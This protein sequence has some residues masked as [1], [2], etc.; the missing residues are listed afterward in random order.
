MND[1]VNDVKPPPPTRTSV[2]RLKD[3]KSLAEAFQTEELKSLIAA[4]APKF[5]DPAAMLRT[6][7]QAAARQPLIYK[8]DFR[9]ALGAF[10]SLAFLGLQP[11]THLN[12]AHIIPFKKKSWN[13]LTR[14]RDKESVEIQVII[15]YPGYIELAHRSGVVKAL[16]ADVV[17]DA[18]AEEFDYEY[19]T[20]QHLRHRGKPPGFKPEHDPLYAYAWFKLEHADQFEVM[21]WNEVLTIRSRSQ[22]YRT[23]ML[24]HDEAK[25]ENKRIPSTYTDA[26]WIRDFEEMGKKSALRRGMKWLPKCPELRAA[27]ALED[28]QDSGAL[29]W[30]PVIDGSA[31]PLDG[32]IPEG[33]PDREDA[34][35]P[36]VAGSLQTQRPSQRERQPREPRQPPPKVQDVEVL[37]FEAGIVDEFGEIA[38]DVITDPEQF[39]RAL[40]AHWRRMPD[41]SR[42]EALLDFNADA[43]DALDKMFPRTRPIIAE[44]RPDD[45]QDEPQGAAGEPVGSGQ[46][47]ERY[48]PAAVPAG[49][50]SGRSWASYVADVKAALATIPPGIE[51]A[52]RW[53]EA[54]QATLVSAPPAQRLLAINAISQHLAKAGLSAVPAWMSDLVKPKAK[55][56]PPSD[57]QGND[58]PPISADEKQ[59]EGFEKNVQA[60]LNM[61]PG[62]APLVEFESYAKSGAVQA[63]MKRLRE[64]N[65][66]LYDRAYR[67]FD[68]GQAELRKRAAKSPPASGDVE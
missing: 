4:A 59:V 20:N 51:A 47:D 68:A 19:G 25:A 2:A 15:G 58:A 5:I 56:A 9:Q 30:G 13:P 64:T 3:C 27:A 11:N 34:G 18:R 17:Y 8:A 60:Y 1:T 63:A 66:P 22:S 50:S 40:L 36:T 29:D 28:A 23:A 26:P 33:E 48:A 49:G 44:I 46:P 39:A 31:S 24:A 43:L 7:I 67:A 12:L 37:T 38:S 61:E 53:A 57:V 52:V 32:D 41:K 42:T 6:W 21:T 54:Q 35:D 16:H 55:T 14:K 45:V 10:Q 65:T 62:D